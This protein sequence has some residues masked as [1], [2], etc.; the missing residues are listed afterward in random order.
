MNLNGLTIKPQEYGTV[1]VAHP[2]T[3]QAN[4]TTIKAKC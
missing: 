3:V 1:L 2:T 4:P